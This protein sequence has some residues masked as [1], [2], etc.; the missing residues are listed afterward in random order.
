MTTLRIRSLSI[1]NVLSFYDKTSLRFGDGVTTFVGPNGAGK[2]NVLRAI[3]L[4]KEVILREFSGLNSQ[5]YKFHEQRAEAMCPAHSAGERESE[6][7]LEVELLSGAKAP[8]EEAGLNGDAYLL[9]LFL[10]GVELSAITDSSKLIDPW[11]EVVQHP[12]PRETM[13]RALQ[14]GTLVLRHL[15]TLDAKWMMAYEFEHGGIKYVWGVSQFGGLFSGA[16]RRVAADLQS[17]PAHVEHSTLTTFSRDTSGVNQAVVAPM[18]PGAD[19]QLSLSISQRLAGAGI[20]TSWDELLIAGIIPSSNRM[21]RARWSLESILRV[22]F[23]DRLNYDFEELFKGAPFVTTPAILSNPP[24]SATD[25]GNPQVPDHLVRLFRSSVGNAVEHRYFERTNQVFAKLIG[26]QEAALR[27]EVTFQSP[28]SSDPNAEV[29]PFGASITVTPVVQLSH[30]LNGVL[31]LVSFGSGVGEILKLAAALTAVN[32]GVVLIDEPAAHLHPTAQE[33]IRSVLESGD[34]SDLT[35]HGQLITVSHSPAFLPVASKGI[36]STILTRKPFG[37][38]STPSQT[39]VTQYSD[40]APAEW[41][42]ISR[43]LRMQPRL[44]AIPFADLLVLVCGESEL[45]LFDNWIRAVDGGKSSVLVLSYGGD[46]NL[47][48]SVRLA[49]FYGVP[50]KAAIDGKLLAPTVL[51]NGQPKVPKFLTDDAIPPSWRPKRDEILEGSSSQIPNADKAKAGWRD[52]WLG[53]LPNFGV[54]TLARCWHVGESRP[55]HCDVTKNE[56][57]ESLEDTFRVNDI[58]VGRVDGQKKGNGKT[59]QAMDVLRQ[60]AEP[61]EP[62]KMLVLELLRD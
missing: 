12:Q 16:V 30:H 59:M 10:R 44:R 9:S 61:P 15:R 48:D 45:I 51:E 14:R 25:L 33:R 18:L 7:R 1:A 8:Y 27:F 58:A 23:A 29:S 47:A 5:L 37:S 42:E 53:Q 32:D 52:F 4:A 34:S 6:I 26:D 56:H 13:F 41:E 17:P 62:F 43:W 20:G 3:A 49:E 31:P 57:L 60:H 24:S 39:D 22:L 36:G 55:I 2:T 11:R 38:D 40:K 50:T 19:Q 28:G 35:E 46:S 54:C 21:S